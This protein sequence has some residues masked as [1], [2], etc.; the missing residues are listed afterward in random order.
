MTMIILNG[1]VLHPL[2]QTDFGTTLMHRFLTGQRS[3]A[4]PVSDV[5][6]VFE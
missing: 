1:H 6:L 2:L 5:S 3:Y 4:G